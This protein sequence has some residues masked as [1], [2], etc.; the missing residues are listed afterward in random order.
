MSKILAILEDEHSVTNTICLISKKY[1]FQPFCFSCV[2]ELIDNLEMLK[3]VDLFITDFDLYDS[4]VIPLLKEMKKKNV[5]VY[6]V[7]NSGN[8]SAI[9]EIE[10][11]GL[12]NM[13]NRVLDKTENFNVF[14]KNLV[15][16]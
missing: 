15:E 8:P 2:E 7:L 10:K 9:K 12:G 5:D 1:G 14:F 16:N 4:N 13:I 3:L 11:Q 6:T